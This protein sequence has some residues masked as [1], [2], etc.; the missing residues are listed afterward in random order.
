MQDGP[1]EPVFM[2][3]MGA[4]PQPGRRL[5]NRQRLGQVAIWHWSFHAADPTR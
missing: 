3:G 4:H 1:K 2:N 5:L